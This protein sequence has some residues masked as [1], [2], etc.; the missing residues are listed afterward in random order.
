M[1]AENGVIGSMLAVWRGARYRAASSDMHTRPRSGPHDYQRPTPGLDELLRRR[2]RRCRGSGGTALRGARAKPGNHERHR[3]GRSARL[4]RRDLSQ[5][6]DHVDLRA[7]LSHAGSLWPRHRHPD[8]ADHPLRVPPVDR[9][10]PNSA[11]RSRSC[12]VAEVRRDQTLWVYD[13]GLHCV[14]RHRT[15]TLFQSARCGRLDGAPDFSAAHQL[16][17]QLLEYPQAS[18]SH[19]GKRVTPDLTL[20][21]ASG[22]TEVK[23]T[24]LLSEGAFSVTEQIVTQTI[25]VEEFRRSTQALWKEIFEPTGDGPHWILD[26]GTSL[27][28]TLSD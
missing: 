14:D 17:D 4:V 2:R 16:G 3:T 24:S 5:P 7:A 26:T 27:F 1:S 6:G 22:C 21:R 19:A 20:E 11:H 13:R 8:R 28:E 25:A 12:L 9:E 10:R 18:R 15:R 23:E